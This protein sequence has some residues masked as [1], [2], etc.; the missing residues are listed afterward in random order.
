MRKRYIKN[1]IDYRTGGR[2]NARRGGKQFDE[3]DA[4]MTGKGGKKI[5]NQTKQTE[6]KNTPPAEETARLDALN[7][8]QEEKSG[9]LGSATNKARQDLADQLI[10][11][12]QVGGVEGTGEAQVQSASF[13]KKAKTNRKIDS[14]GRSV[15]V[16]GTGR[17]RMGQYSNPSNLSESVELTDEQQAEVDRIAEEE[18]AKQD[19]KA[20]AEAADPTKKDPAKDLIGKARTD[21]LATKTFTPRRARVK[22]LRVEDAKT[23]K[24]KL[25]AGIS[26]DVQQLDAYED[27]TDPTD[28][29]RTTI[30]QTTAETATAETP[31]AIEAASYDAVRAEELDPTE[32]AKGRVSRIAEAE[33]PTLT[34]RSEAAK[35]DAEAEERSLARA[36]D[37]QISDDAFVQKVE[38]QTTDI[39]ETDPAEKNEREAII[40][41]PAPDGQAAQILNEYGFGSSK[42]KPRTVTG[43]KAKELVANQLAADYDLPADVANEIANDI[44]RLNVEEQSQESLGAVAALPKEALVSTQIE[45]LLSGMEEGNPPSWARPAVAAVE[46][47]LAKR[48]LSAST[49]G[50][51][52]LF[53]AIIQSAVPIAQSNATALQQRAAQNLSNEQQALI[54]DRQIAASFLE[55]NAAFKQQMELANLSN[56]QQMRLANLTALNQASSENLNAAQQTD[57]ANLNARLQTNLLSNKIAADMN[58]AQL[59][60]DQ[61]RAVANA[62]MVAKVDMAQFSAE[63]QVELANSKFM[64]TATLT[65]YNARQQSAVQNATLMAQMDLAAADQRTKLAITNA[66]NFLKMDLANLSNEQQSLVLDQQLKQQRILSNQSAENAALQFNAVSENQ[67]NQFMAN[68]EANM[69]QFNTAQTNSM[70]QFNAAE[71][72]KISAQNAANDI[73]AAKF[74]TQMSVQVKQFNEQMD[75]QRDTWN[76]QNAQ[77]V[78][79]SN[80]EW[81]RKANTIDNAAQN[82]SNM[83]NA[84]QAFAINSAEQNFIWQEL[85]DQAAYLRQNYENDQQRRTT[86]YATAIANETSVAEKSKVRPDDLITDIAGLYSTGKVG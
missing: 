76:A 30:K 71:A 50:R 70:A 35:R 15:Q 85:R 40:G 7:K 53:N 20:A 8:L 31:D 63:Q 75:L 36:A 28:I 26:T 18:K 11:N 48:G 27:I 78:E 4:I 72:N 49:V 1:R 79:Q 58:Q 41:M 6:T 64:Q 47:M 56:D 51:D 22:K 81:R 83:L 16:G 12:E 54:Q 33:G 59:T 68:L 19:A 13:K 55:K 60:V 65:D 80:I 84:Q 3:L 44:G 43:Q 45:S 32:A 62:T 29:E 67:T 73:A 9:L 74:D 39:V 77:A 37:Y 5:P 69:N 2:V 61:Q 42:R 52:A 82:A 66:Q 21:D 14:R 24:E 17:G 86:L 25:K 46:Q 23:D 10:A 34:E 57:L 38:G